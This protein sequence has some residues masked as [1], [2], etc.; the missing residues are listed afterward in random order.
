MSTTKT[1]V[2]HDARERGLMGARARWGEQPR[3]V[4]LDA[5]TPEQRA[6]VIALVEAHASANRAAK[7]AD[8]AA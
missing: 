2:I 3:I 6:V 8:D 4:R 7:A 1:V 5:L